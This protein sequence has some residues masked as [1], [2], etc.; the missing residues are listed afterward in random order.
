MG[1]ALV[2]IPHQEVEIVKEPDAVA[3]ELTVPIDIRRKGKNEHMKII[4][5]ENDKHVAC[6]S[7]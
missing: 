1:V 4:E 3:N 5:W 7:E 6:H 2:A